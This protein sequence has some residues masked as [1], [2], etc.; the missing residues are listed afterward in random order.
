M[1]TELGDRRGDGGAD[2]PLQP[3]HP[4]QGTGHGGPRVPGADHGQGPAV[5]DGLGGPH[6]R[7]VLL[8]ADPLA[9]ILVHADD[10]GG[11]E[12]LEPP[13]V[14]HLV[15]RAN[16]DDRRSRVPRRPGGRRPRSRPAP[17]HRPW[18]RPPPAT[19]ARRRGRGR[20]GRRP[21]VDFDGLSALVPPAVRADH[22]G[23]LGVLAL[24]ADAAGRRPSTQFEARRLRLFA[25][26]VFFLG[27]AIVGHLRSGAGPRYPVGPSHEG[28]L[29]RPTGGSPRSAS[30]LGSQVGNPQDVEGGPALVAWHLA[31][32]R[33]LVAVDPA[34]GA[35]APT[36]LVAQRGRW[37]ARGGRRRARGPPGRPASSISG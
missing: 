4:Q 30:V 27:T 33:L 5:A 31:A 11:G 9:G 26:D 6:E 2:D 17:G 28:T 37:G 36:R 19:G 14:T 12:D 23:H 10:L 1:G 32:A 34:H 20:R 24:R 18:R 22:V 21:L 29:S 15:G 16:Q 25:L 35:Q 8:A 3:A 13:G 7:G